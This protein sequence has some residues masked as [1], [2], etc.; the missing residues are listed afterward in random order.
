MESPQL[1]HRK[2]E[3]NDGQNQ[4][5]ARRDQGNG[6]NIQAGHIADSSIPNTYHRGAE[7]KA[8]NDSAPPKA[9]C[10]NHH[11]IYDIAKVFAWKNRQV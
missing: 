10:Q 3:H 11:A 5:D 8:R 7:K 1:R 9:A 2:R 4:I 6:G